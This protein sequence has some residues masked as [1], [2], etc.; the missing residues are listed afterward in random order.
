MDRQTDPRTG[1]NQYAPQLLSA[2]HDHVMSL[3]AQMREKHQAW[4][5]NTLKAFS[6]N[7]TDIIQYCFLSLWVPFKDSYVFLTLFHFASIW[8]IW[9]QNE[10]FFITFLFH[11]ASTMPMQN[12]IKKIKMKKKYFITSFCVVS[13][14]SWVNFPVAA[15]Y[16]LE[17]FF[18][19]YQENCILCVLIKIA[20]LNIQL[21]YRRSKRHP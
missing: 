6:F 13:G 5:Q 17:I 15:V 11:F 10:V 14:L 21:F 4:H 9:M 7:T 2:L 20:S 18:L 19:F 8:S 12:E 16:I 3:N 1:P